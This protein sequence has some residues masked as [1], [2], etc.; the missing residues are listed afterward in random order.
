VNYLSSICLCRHRR[1]MA[2]GMFLVFP[3]I[4]SAQDTAPDSFREL[5]SKYIFGF[6]FGSDIGPEG[7][8]E[9]ELTT[10]IDFQRRT[11]S[12]AA[13]EQEAELEYN[14]TDRFQIELGAFGFYHA[15]SGVEGFG[16]FHG[17]NF[18]G[19]ESTFRYILIARGP[20]S[21]IGLQ[22][23]AQPEWSRVDSAGKLVTTFEAETRLIADTEL[24]PDRLFAA[25]NLIYTPEI[26]REFGSPKWERASTLGV[27][28]ALTYRVTPKVALGAELEYYR[29]CEGLGLNTLAGSALYVGPTFHMQ[30]TNEFILAAAFSTQI[31]GHAVGDA[32]VLDLTN[33]SR[34]KAFL[35]AVFEF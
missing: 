3:A 16:D 2:A 8:R 15:I 35:R 18:G 9:L 32:N 19:I 11:G 30:V 28:G 5:E 27:L 31:A 20:G 34:N 10:R 17:A 6:L 21:P 4:S 12:Y 22:I 14:R 25:F 24:V 29:A 26:E 13:L 1:T 23:S 7:E 33:F